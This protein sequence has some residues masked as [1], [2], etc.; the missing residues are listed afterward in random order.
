[1]KISAISDVHVKLPHDEADKLLMAFLN[2]PLV[3]SSNYIFLLGDIFDLMC[4][5]HSPYIEDF[6]HI[7]Q[8][9]DE[10]LNSGVKVYYC[11]GN[12]DVHL[13]RLFKLYW[14][15]GKL[16]PKQEPVIET[17]DD[18]I[19]YFS[20]GDEHEVDNLSY[21]KYK[22]IILSAPLRL[23]ANRIMPYAVLNLIGMRASKVSRKKGAR[24]FDEELVK[25]RFREGVE[26]T[27]QGRYDF[28]LGGHSHVKDNYLMKNRS[29]TY[30]NN[31][32]ALRSRSF[33]HIDN[34]Q[35]SFPAL[36]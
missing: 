5:P 18:K 9:L 6:R 21:Q 2:D 10:L 27:T 12:H 16:V 15:E 34:H 17:I 23:V 4:G 11:E 22:K 28:V 32:Y 24:A 20:H 8:R 33:I 19:Y 3:T 7:F 29:S 35:V 25:S 31:G 36:A 13:E 26:A 14:P 30:I 1:M